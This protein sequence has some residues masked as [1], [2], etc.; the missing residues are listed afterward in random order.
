MQPGGLLVL[1]SPEGLCGFVLEIWWN[2]FF[3]RLQQLHSMPHRAAELHDAIYSGS[4]NGQHAIVQALHPAVFPQIPEM[5]GHVLLRTSQDL[6]EVYDTH[7]GPVGIVPAGGVENR[8]DRRAELAVRRDVVS[9]GFLIED[10]PAGFTDL[11]V[12]G[13]VPG[14]LL[15]VG[16]HPK[17][18][19]ELSEAL[20]AAA[21]SVVRVKTLGQVPEDALDGVLVC[22]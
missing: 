15:S 17:G 22:S 14:A 19:H 16:Q 8:K 18:I 11:L 3:P 12:V 4:G 10:A 1:L 20:G 2:G 6:L 7:P 21:F 9:G 13:I 5:K